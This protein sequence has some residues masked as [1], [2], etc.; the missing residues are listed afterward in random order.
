MDDVAAPTNTTANSLKAVKWGGG[1]IN[2]LVYGIKLAP[3]IGIFRIDRERL[4]RGKTCE[5]CF[6]CLFIIYT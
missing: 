2:K 6:V 3:G 1:A 4:R 5:K